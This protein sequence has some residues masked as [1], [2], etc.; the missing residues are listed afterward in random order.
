M[1]FEMPKMNVEEFEIVDV[2]MTSVIEEP[3]Q[4]ENDLPED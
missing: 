4:N 3:G 1:K 2:I